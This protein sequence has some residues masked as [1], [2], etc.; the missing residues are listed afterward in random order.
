MLVLMLAFGQPVA[1]NEGSYLRRGR[2]SSETDRFWNMPDVVIAPDMFAMP[3]TSWTARPP[4][5]IPHR[6]RFTER[7][8]SDR[9]CSCA[10]DRELSRGRQIMLSS[11][12]R[13][14]QIATEAVNRS[15]A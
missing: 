7:P 15:Q 5:S 12:S 2:K 4:H 9:A 14:S 8:Q 6:R 10:R 3:S 13:R 1:A 11:P